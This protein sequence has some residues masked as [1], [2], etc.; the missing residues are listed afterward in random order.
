M[1]LRTRLALLVGAVFVVG[2]GIIGGSSALIARQEAVDAVDA[3]LGDAISSVKNDPTQDVSAVLEIA[4]TSSEPISALLF[5]DDSEPLVLIE[6]RDGTEAVAFPNLSIAEVTRAAEKPIDKAGVVPLRIAAYS[7]GNGEWLVVASSMSSVNNQFGK[8]LIRSVQLSLL[9]AAF[10]VVL[11]YWLIR[12]ALLP[13]ARV[14]RD[15]RAIAEGNLDRE[16]VPVAGKS[17]IGQLSSS[18]QEMVNSLRSAVETT[19][20]SE[21]LM[22]EFLGDASHELRTPLTVIRGYVEILNSGQELSEEQRE[23]AMSRL[24]SESQRMS[25]TINDLLLLAELGEVRHEMTDVVDLSLL[26]ANY[27][28]DFSEQQKSRI[29]KSTIASDVHIVGNSEQLSRMISNVISNIS[30]HTAADAEVEVVLAE[31][32]GKAIIV[33]DDAGPGL[34]AEL[35]ART[36]EGFQRFDRAHSKT[37]GGFGL[38]LSILSS[39][40][41]RHGGTLSLSPSPLGGLRTHI[42]LPISAGPPA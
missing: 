30:R 16:I 6:A 37:G 26:A 4:E 31:V 2:G 36:V 7:T 13:I 12:R 40:V 39:I 8:S 42:T 17:E 20:R 14:T 29:V 3:V 1:K 32:D 35:Y 25:Q 18:L 19:T 23:R 24:L 27:V 5:F 10:M 38:G 21:A 34:S 9:I 15:A 11:I 28:R 22:R 41:S 33:F